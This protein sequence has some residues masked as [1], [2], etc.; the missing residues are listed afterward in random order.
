MFK[1]LSLIICAISAFAVLSASAAPF[2]L[3][4][5]D[6]MA[7]KS[8]GKHV[9]TR[10][11]APMKRA[12]TDE[13]VSRAYGI[14]IYDDVSMEPRLV[15]FEVDN[16]GE[17]TTEMDLPFYTARAA[18]GNEN[19]YYIIDSSDG[20]TNDNFYKLD[21][22]TKELSLVATYDLYSLEKGLII[23]DMTYDET[24]GNLYAL[25]I[26]IDDINMPD[27]SGSILVNWMGLYT[28]DPATGVATLVGN[29]DSCNLIALAMSPDG[30]L[31][32]LDDAGNIWE[33]NKNTGKPGYDIGYAYDIP[34]GLQSLDFDHSDG[35]LYWSAF[36]INGEDGTGFFAKFRMAED[37]AWYERIGDCQNNA[38]IIGL[39][40]DD[41]PLHPYAPAAVSDLAIVPAAGGIGEA[42]LTWTNPTQQYG[43]DALTGPFKVNIY[44][45]DTKVG[46]V[47]NCI[48]GEAA[49]YTDT[50]IP[51]GNYVYK[52]VA[53]NE[54]GEGVEVFCP[55]VFIGIDTPGA[56]QSLTA[57]KSADSYDI[58]LTWEAPTT[59]KSNGW[60]DNTTVSYTVTRYPGAIVLAKDLTATSFIDNTISET[61][62]YS[63]GVTAVNATGTGA[64]ATSAV[65]VS[66]PAL[67]V[68]YS[69]NFT[70][71]EQIR[72]WTIVDNDKDGE[73]WHIEDNYA[74]TDDVF[75]EYNPSFGPDPSR[76]GD[77]WFI[78]APIK[79]S[80]GKTYT[81]RYSLRILFYEFFPA[82]YKVAIGQGVTPDAMTSVI[83]DRPGDRNS[84]QQVFVDYVVPF[85]VAEDGE[86]NIGFHAY[87]AVLMQ[88][89]NIVVEEAIPV[90]LDITAFYGSPAIIVDNAS[91]LNVE[92]FN[93]GTM[94][95]EDVKV[96]ISDADGNEVASAVVA[97]PIAAHSTAKVA[98]PW[99]PNAVGD[100]TLSAEVV[101]A[102]D[103]NPENNKSDDV[104]TVQV[105]KSGEWSNITEGTSES[106][107]SP[108]QLDHAH[109]AIQT[110][111]SS[112]MISAEP[113]KIEGLKYYYYVYEQQP[114]EAFKA[115]VYLA[116]T[117]VA[118]YNIRG[119]NPIP[120]DE[121][122]LVFD[123]EI[124]I[125][126]DQYELYIP[127]DA[128]FEYT[129]GH[130]CVYTV[131]ESIGGC[132]A[133]RWTTFFMGEYEDTRTLIYRGDTA[134]TFDEEMTAYNDYVNI[135]FYLTAG[136]S[137]VEDVLVSPD[138]NAEVEWFNLQGVRLKGDKLAPGIYIRRQGNIV[139]K[140]QVN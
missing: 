79:L 32:A 3:K 60:F 139:T 14:C 43:G 22:I 26:N 50:G 77:D 34:A 124:K 91:E 21:L 49:S 81:V 16:P 111:Y 51:S 45:D 122:T 76:R 15:S 37:G 137:G 138:G 115:K 90:D 82:S 38:E 39:H 33:M 30:M 107:G 118:D 6:L 5:S 63:Y 85:T 74:G 104:L 125:D 131:Q 87:N 117:T 116:N 96:I 41:T 54:N 130:L 119:A 13:L 86:Y 53:E 97:E 59:G 98:I 66:G 4:N 132:I 1:K 135:S 25:A 89:T 129:G 57:S 27:D 93:D 80:K 123:G 29:Q 128:P 42:T 62:G 35:T 64:T 17:I 102:S 52:A 106:V 10:Q 12:A 68:P 46:T 24:S 8:S 110:I 67:D 71:D 136:E 19:T 73:T 28:I 99:T 112:D 31:V 133:V 84:E 47:E 103:I 56:P 7:F 134:F 94:T 65:I 109:S 83:V 70:T 58:T 88:F 48:A 127:L 78:S 18:A 2:S 69:C 72:L 108:F 100:E 140:V 121:F 126:S 61:D 20:V 120:F 36:S 114:V 95:A 9:A 75:M 23:Y 113:A 44:R 40:I 92:I 55:S 105:L 11:S 101:S